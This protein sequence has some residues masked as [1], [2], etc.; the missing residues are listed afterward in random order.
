M[1]SPGVHLKTDSMHSDRALLLVAIIPLAIYCLAHIGSLTS[2]YTINDDVRQQIY[3]M[4]QYRDSSLFQDHLLSDYA[5]SY[6]PWGVQFLYWV[7][8]S[9]MEP[10]LFSKV[11]TA[12]LFIAASSLM[13]AIVH[14][15]A[16]RRS[17]LMTLAIF[18]YF[19][20]SLGSIS[21]GLSRGFVFPLL[22][23]YLY[24]LLRKKYSEAGLV[25]LAQSLVNPY[26]FL[27]GFFT[28]I[29]A[30]F[31]TIKNRNPTVHY[32][33]TA[34]FSRP[35]GNYV[36]SLIPAAIGLCLLIFR[37]TVAQSLEIGPVA[38]LADM[39][40][41]PEFTAL[42]RY[43]ILPL[44]PLPYEFVRPFLKYP[45]FGFFSVLA[46]IIGVVLY[47]A[48]VIRGANRSMIPAALRRMNTLHYLLAA[49]LVLYMLARIFLLQLFLPERY[50][51][52]PLTIVYC[53]FLGLI[54]GAVLARIPRIF[55]CL[56]LGVLLLCGAGRLHSIAISDYQEQQ[57][58]YEFFEQSPTDTLIAGHPEV[59]DN[60]MTFARRK[61][62]L[63][64][65]LS[66]P[67]YLQYWSTIK[68]RTNDFF[69]AYYGDNPD[70]IISFC[71]NN[72][73]SY[74][75]VRESD[76]AEESVYRQGVYFEPFNS[77]IQTLYQ[78]HRSFALLDTDIFK[79]VFRYGE[80]RIIS[81]RTDQ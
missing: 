12:I 79:P 34:F 23:A 69:A 73:I 43:E 29:L 56:V 9:I 49:S 20:N 81:F 11:L 14:E 17:G 52:Y 76:F 7:A 25:L 40:G 5:K 1:A 35:Y 60:V 50:L 30:G 13:Y 26:L 65:E 66:H 58:L 45:P 74:L 36:L 78:N 3:W 22:L 41:Q 28:H 33:G 59:M 62:F 24:L 19:G 21:G 54:G 37:Y 71:R 6:V 2:T 80:Y 57:S 72:G 32:T 64:Y 63:S 44:R 16:D 46:T 77:L 51:E 68:Q 27:I 31:P 53:I 15:V 38:S 47:C 10:I 39:E 4:Q 67:W 48:L 8:A 42:G 18:F 55:F 70:K 61:V 75:V